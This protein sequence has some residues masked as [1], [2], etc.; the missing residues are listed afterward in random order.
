MKSECGLQTTFENFTTRSR[1]GRLCTFCKHYLSERDGTHVYA[2]SLCSCLIPPLHQQVART[3]REEGQHTQLQHRWHRQEGKQVVPPGHLQSKHQQKDSRASDIDKLKCLPTFVLF[4]IL[5]CVYNC[6]S[7]AN[8]SCVSMPVFS[9]FSLS[10]RLFS[11]CP[12]LLLCFWAFLL[13]FILNFSLPAFF[14]MLLDFGLWTLGFRCLPHGVCIW[15]PTILTCLYRTDS[16]FQ[17]R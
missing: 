17:F 13:S 11:S 1:C 12:L 4:P 3:L 7:L 9:S 15:V 10:V 2:T 16:R 5:F 6:V 8:R 14:C